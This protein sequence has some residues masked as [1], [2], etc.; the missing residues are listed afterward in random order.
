MMP[1]IYEK[2]CE[3]LALQDPLAALH[4]P[5]AQDT[6]LQPFTSSRGIKNLHWKNGDKEFHLHDEDVPE[7]EIK[8][9]LASRN[10][11]NIDVIYFF[12]VGLGYSWPVLLSWLQR[13]SKRRLVYLEDDLAVLK[14]FLETETATE[15]LLHPQVQV[16]VFH[17]I[18]EEKS[19]FHALTWKHLLKQ[20]HVFSLPSYA[21]HRKEVTELLQERLTYESANKNE[22]VSEFL[23]HGVV[24]YR[25]FYANMKHLHRC[26]H[27]NAMFGNFVKV[28]AIICGAGPSINKHLELLK[29][30][31]NRALI[32]AGGSGINALNGGNMNP[33]FGG[34]IDPNAAQYVRYRQNEAYEVPFFFR[35]RLQSDAFLVIDGPKLYVNGSG[36]Y[37]TGKWFDEKLGIT[38]EEIDEGHNIANFL[39]NIAVHLGCDPIIFVGM[40]LA[41]TE[42]ESYAKHV[43][44]HP[45]V[46]ED[47]I[48][49]TSLFE[50]GA[51]L[52]KDINGKPTYTMWKWMSEAQWISDLA[53]A[54]AD[55]SFINA[56][57]GGIGFEGI[58]NVTLHELAEKKLLSTHDFDGIVHQEIQGASLPQITKDK[59]FEV[60]M[61]LKKS[62]NICITHLETLVEDAQNSAFKATVGEFFPEEGLSGLGVLA[63][64]DLKDEPAYKAVLEVFE[65]VKRHHLGEQIKNPDQIVTLWSFLL[66]TA[67][68]NREMIEEYYER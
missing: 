25:N 55:R 21:A 30:L 45:Q 33:H 6:H 39:A 8:N 38:S 12:G 62:L 61:E 48:V 47:E 15:V 4:L 57:E 20:I 9:T 46:E 23:Q 68:M 40:D 60:M 58:P 18:E 27:G 13:N 51:I 49:A 59:V 54:H 29:E 64:L 37:E 50:T 52:R 16:V 41:Y 28:P 44:E 7:E 34:G 19:T 35:P 17:K 42:M 11:S 65:K 5:K 66:E 10:L 43:V 22:I 14:Y 63:E 56:T 36:G 26:Y 67:M 3:L 1:S 24:F 2:N 32:F 31:Q 53:K